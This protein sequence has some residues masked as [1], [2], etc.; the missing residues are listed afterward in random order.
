MPAVSTY[1][2]NQCSLVLEGVTLAQ[3]V[4]LV[5]EVLIDLAA[6]TVL[7]KKTTE[8]SETAHP[9]NLAANLLI[10]GLHRS[11][12]R[13]HLPWHTSISCTLS[14]T[15]TTVS[16]NSSC[17][18]E[19]TGAGSRMHGDGLSDDKAICNELSDGLAR[20]GVGDFTGLVGIEP[21]L[22]LSTAD[23]GGRQALLGCKIDPIVR[24]NVS[25]C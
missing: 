12:L 21:D 19:L 3:V 20:V 16:A 6:G 1:V 5:V 24:K 4:K 11:Y 22:A 10:Y 14:L 7:D 18:C 13:Y 2:L 23:D 8:D 15:E 9:D 17:S 25:F